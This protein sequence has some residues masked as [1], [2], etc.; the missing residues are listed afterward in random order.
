MHPAGG[1]LRGRRPRPPGDALAADGPRLGALLVHAEPRAC[2]GLQ[3]ARC[4]RPVARAQRGGGA[5][6]PV[7]PWVGPAGP[8][9]RPRPRRAPPPAHARQPAAVPV[10]RKGGAPR[11]SVRRDGERAAAGAAARAGLRLGVLQGARGARRVARGAL[12]TPARPAAPPVQQP[13]G[14]RPPGS[15]TGSAHG[16]EPSRVGFVTSVPGRRVR[17]VGS[18]QVAAAAVAARRA[19]ARAVAAARCARGRTRDARGGGARH[20]GVGAAS[21]PPPGTVHR[22][23]ACQRR[24]RR[25]QQQL[26]RR[27]GGQRALD[28][29]HTVGHA[30]RTARLAPA[31]QGVAALGPLHPLR[32]AAA[33]QHAARPHRAAG[34]HGARCP[35][36]RHA[37][38]PHLPAARAHLPRGQAGHAPPVRG[39]HS[40]RRRH[41]GRPT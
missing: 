24:R 9:C 4:R 3:A 38:R 2:V 34:A 37:G 29:G 6:A 25:Q 23:A 18:E 39:R 35:G 36:P 32:P 22:L 40:H 41:R 17:A 33:L 13:S 12:R 8:A 16:G 21:G 1:L 20:R 14:A 11:A 31:A 15:D 26:H 5:Y 10:L 19:T 27:C 30:S 28:E 7:R